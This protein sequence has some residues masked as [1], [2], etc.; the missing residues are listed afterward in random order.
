MKEYSWTRR[1]TLVALIITLAVMALVYT[2]DST[3]EAHVA[4]GTVACRVPQVYGAARFS[5]PSAGSPVNVVFEDSDA[6]LRFVDVSKPDCE[7]TL[8]ITRPLH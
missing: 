2:L 4:P 6:T 3:V 1:S 5:G 8:T 7:V